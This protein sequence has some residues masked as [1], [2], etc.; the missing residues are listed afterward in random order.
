MDPSPGPTH[1]SAV[2]RADVAQAITTAWPGQL[3]RRVLEVVSSYPASG[4]LAHRVAHARAA[5][6]DPAHLLSLMHITRLHWALDHARAPAAVLAGHLARHL[7]RPPPAAG[8]ASQLRVRPGRPDLPRVRSQRAHLVL[9]ICH[10]TPAEGTWPALGGSPPVEQPTTQGAKIVYLI[11]V[12]HQIFEGFRDGTPFS[13]IDAM[14]EVYGCGNARVLRA[15]GTPVVER[16]GSSHEV[17]HAPT[18]RII[19]RRL[20]ERAH[21]QRVI[22]QVELA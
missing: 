2:R 19:Q 6:F 5:G 4:A 11:Q 3:G 16:A 8:P 14:H 18:G 1:S 22:N 17:V 13:L 7:A 10:R 12:D 21:R 20:T 15:D 9:T